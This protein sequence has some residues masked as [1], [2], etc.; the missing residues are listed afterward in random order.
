[1][2]EML[3]IFNVFSIYVIKSIMNSLLKIILNSIYKFIFPS[4]RDELTVNF[5]KELFEENNKITFDFNL[6]MFMN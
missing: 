4:R 2:L 3:L 5:Y 6:I 1:M